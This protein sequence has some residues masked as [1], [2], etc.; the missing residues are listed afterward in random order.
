MHVG[1]KACSSAGV[2]EAASC[3]MDLPLFIGF[4]F[5]DAP[6]TKVRP[7]QII[8]ES[9]D[10]QR[11]IESVI[12]RLRAMQGKDEQ[13]QPQFWTAG[14]EE[15]DD[16]I[17]QPLQGVMATIYANTVAKHFPAN[18]SEKTMQSG[19]PYALLTLGVTWLDTQ[20]KDKVSCG[21]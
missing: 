17:E 6:D 14:L 7:I 19:T 1:E 10:E 15:E 5:A 13:L 8:K 20:P 12:Q 11:M 16:D 9:L 3:R 2:V 4:K 18:Y 21:V